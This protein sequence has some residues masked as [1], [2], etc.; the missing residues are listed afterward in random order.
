[1]NNKL[2]PQYLYLNQII[3]DQIVFDQTEYAT[4][5]GYIFNTYTGKLINWDFVLHFNILTDILLFAKEEGEIVIKDVSDKIQKGIDPPTITDVCELTGQPLAV[6]NLCLK[7]Y[8]PE[9]QNKSS[10]NFYMIESIIPIQKLLP[11][12]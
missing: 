1:M 12:K 8:K 7:V 3:I 10:D 11:I 5:F 6:N 4:I 2:S 9:E